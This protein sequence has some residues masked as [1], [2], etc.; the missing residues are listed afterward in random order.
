MQLVI[1]LATISNNNF[2]AAVRSGLLEKLTQEINSADVLLQLN[3]IEI[4]ANFMEACGR[5]AMK[6]LKETGAL[7]ELG[8]RLEHIE[9]EPLGAMLLPYLVRFFGRVICCHPAKL[10]QQ[11]PTYLQCLQ[12]C[13]FDGSVEQQVLAA[14]TL[15]FLTKKPEG[16]QA[17]LTHSEL[18]YCLGL[19][20]FLVINCDASLLLKNLVFVSSFS[21]S[22]ATSFEHQL[23]MSHIFTCVQ[24]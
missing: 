13:L 11:H 18:L 9:D 10:L 23:Y 19:C 6:L 22:K 14:E 3:I 2:Q 17:L 15:G 4:L 5:P 20:D 1:E 24:C 12:R 16:K 7:T 8:Y 21:K